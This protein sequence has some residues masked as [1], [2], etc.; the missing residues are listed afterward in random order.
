MK[1]PV[2][3]D[4]AHEPYKR[5]LV[6]ADELRVVRVA[7]RAEHDTAPRLDA[8]HFATALRL[9]AD[10]TLTALDEPLHA[11]LGQDLDVAC[12]QPRFELGRE[13]AAAL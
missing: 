9:D 11:V 12:A 7:T 3:P 13:A 2:D 1:S 8:H 10:D 4:A 6:Q 5:R